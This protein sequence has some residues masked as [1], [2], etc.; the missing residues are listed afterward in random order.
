MDALRKYVNLPV[1]LDNIKNSD[2]LKELGF[3]CRYL[4]DP[5]E[6]FDEFE[7][8]TALAGISNLGLMVTVEFLKIKR[9]FFGLISPEDPDRVTG[10]SETQLNSIFE[11]SG[12]EVFRFFDF[13]TKQG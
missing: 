4:P 1:N 8:G 6:D 2:K 5:P 12:A 11:Q 3:V 7:F 9:I 13:I 10:V